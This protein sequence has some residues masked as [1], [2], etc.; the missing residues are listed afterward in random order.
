MKSPLKRHDSIS[1][2]GR[3]T[4]FDDQN[5]V[6]E[7]TPEV[8]N[9]SNFAT[10]IQITKSAAAKQIAS[11][12]RR[13][14]VDYEGSKALIKKAREIAGLSPEPKPKR[15]PALLTDI[16]LKR[17]FKAV[18]DVGNLQHKLMIRV[19][20]FTGVRVTELTN[21]KR[22]DVDLENCTI[23]I[24]QGKGSKD[25]R[26]LFPESLKLSLNAYMEATGGA[27]YL[28]ESRHCQKYTS[29]RIQQIVSRFAEEAG[30]SG[31]VHCHLFRH[32]CLTRLTREGLT[33]AQIQ[34]ISGHA[35]KKSLEV[36]QHLSLASVTDDYQKA[37]ARGV[38]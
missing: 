30:L 1:L 36:Y 26:T 7:L 9:Q 35:S 31:R 28:F 25:R 5:L 22:T 18:D 2:N 10:P 21:I 32:M 8:A 38:F 34:L 12:L 33:D 3:N 20:Y 37:M 15:Q 16:E 23:R 6:P 4:K 27:I 17:F 13:S 24:E 29:R 19:L 11:I 14:R